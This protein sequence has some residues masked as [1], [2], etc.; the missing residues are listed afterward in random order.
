M[1]ESA[2]KVKL[3]MLNAVE[4]ND[5][6]WVL[7]GYLLHSQATSDGFESTEPTL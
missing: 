4:A 1:I 3:Y 2:A 6:P 5:I 7:T